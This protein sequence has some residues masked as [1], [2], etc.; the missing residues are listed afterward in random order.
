MAGCPPGHTFADMST[1]AKVSPSAE[2]A[3]ALAQSFDPLRV[4]GGDPR[5]VWVSRRSPER[6]L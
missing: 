2:S 4:A 3:M 1:T 5:V 6:R